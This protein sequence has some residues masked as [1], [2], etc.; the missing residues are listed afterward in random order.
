MLV[1][2]VA[3]VAVSVAPPLWTDLGPGY[4]LAALLLGSWFVAVCVRHRRLPTA[5]SAGRVFRASMLYLAALFLA[6]AAGGAAH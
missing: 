3:T 4:V 6:A 5:A 1:Y 2:A